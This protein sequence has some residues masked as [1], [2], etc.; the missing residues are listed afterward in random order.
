MMKFIP[1]FLFLYSINILACECVSLSAEELS[2]QSDVIFTGKVITL[3][4]LDQRKSDKNLADLSGPSVSIF[5]PDK[6][7]KNPYGQI[8]NLENGYNEVF[9]IQEGANCDVF[10]KE[11]DEFLIFGKATTWGVY[12]TNSCMGSNSLELSSSL[13]LK[14]KKLYSSY[15][16]T[17]KQ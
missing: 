16:E 7:F 10:L 1:F 3:G 6:V 17:N 9:V 13:L 4:P 12:F 15:E 8:G 2:R 5:Q 11:G 14:L